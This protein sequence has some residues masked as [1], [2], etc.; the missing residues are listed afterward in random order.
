LLRP[1]RI[2]LLDNF[3]KCK[4]GIHIRML[5]QIRGFEEKTIQYSI[6]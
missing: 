4:C 3:L 5:A 2:E 6:L 1:K